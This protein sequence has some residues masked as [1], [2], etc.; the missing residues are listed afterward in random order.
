L[1]A[2]GG[3]V[4][5]Q[6]WEDGELSSVKIH[7][8]VGGSTEIN[9]IDGTESYA[10]K[11]FMLGS[12]RNMQGRDKPEAWEAL[13]DWIGEKMRR[14]FDATICTG[15]NITTLLKLSYRHKDALKTVG[16]LQAIVDEVNALSIS[17]RIEELGLREDRADVLPYASAIY[18]RAM[19]LSES[20]NVLIPNVGLKDGITEMLFQRNC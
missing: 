20:E 14:P 1:V 5:D 2:R 3:F 6:K 17:E 7:A 12:V 4:I 19:A 10:W 8:R 15:G 18:L 13:A 16:Q 9:M 11:S